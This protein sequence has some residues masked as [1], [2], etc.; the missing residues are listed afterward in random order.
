MPKDTKNTIWVV[1]EEGS[2]K[3]TL[4]TLLPIAALRMGW[5]LLPDDNTTTGQH[6]YDWQHQLFSAGK[7]PPSWDDQRAKDFTFSHLNPEEWQRSQL[8]N[9]RQRNHRSVVVVEQT[10]PRGDDTLPFS[11]ELS[12]QA[13]VNQEFGV[14]YCL[15]VNHP[16]EASTTH[17]RDIVKALGQSRSKSIR[18]LCIAFTKADLLGQENLPGTGLSRMLRVENF[19][20]DGEDRRH[21]L[22]VTSEQIL[23]FMEQGSV[24]GLRESV[25]TQERLECSFEVCTAVGV[26]KDDTETYRPNVREDN[27]HSADVYD[28][29]Q[30]WWSGIDRVLLRVHGASAP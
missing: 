29:L 27:D 6:I 26:A 2:G 25:S 24:R 3:T 8:M 28:R 9:R 1:G 22:S 10:I 14:I 30:I 13:S 19:G 7:F 23:E 17:L 12:L 15:D 20:E 18:R 11:E 16:S 21:S 4:I 5:I